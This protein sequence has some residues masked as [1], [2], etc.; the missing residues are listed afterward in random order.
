MKHGITACEWCLTECDN[1]HLQCKKC[2]GPI[3]V[4]EPWVLQCGWCSSSNR[5]DLTT[6]C[7][8]CGGELPHIPGTPRYQNHQW[9]LDILHQA[10]RKKSNI[11]KTHLF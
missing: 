3:A 5:R 9:H 1:D 2:G 11:G 6:N 10:M 8:S 4:L 7:N